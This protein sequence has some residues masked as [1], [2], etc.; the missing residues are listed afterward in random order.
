MEKHSLVSVIIP[1]FNGETYIVEAIESVLNQTYPSLEL[2]VVDDGSTD[3]TQ[4]ILKDYHSRLR[5]VSQ[6]NSGVS[7]ARNYGLRLARGEY[8]VFLDADD[9][10]LPT[11]LTNQVACLDREP[12]VGSVHS[13]WHLIDA[14]GEYIETVEP[15]HD[16]PHLDLETWLIWCPFY[17]PAMMFRRHWLESVG[18]FDPTLRQAEDVDLLLRLSLMGC[19]TTWLQQPTVCYRQHGNSTM[20]NGLQQAESITRVMT[21]FLARSDLPV[22]THQLENTILFNTLMWSVWHMYATGYTTEIAGY[23]RQSL[24]Y[25]SY[26]PMQAVR[27][28]LDRLVRACID[29]GYKPEEL[30]TLWPQFKAAIQV[31]DL[32]WQ[33]MESALNRWLKFMM[34]LYAN[35][36]R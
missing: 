4:R 22:E 35:A 33:Q 11:K 13:G 24:A 21:A 30:R 29:K 27:L 16:A 32:L 3:D 20:Q 10:L 19:T 23:L 8:I 2:I 18:G 9:V 36:E 26:S 28:W 7:A 34:V 25:T 15:W 5:C 31:D 1:V 6:Q 14:Q 12:D 17:L